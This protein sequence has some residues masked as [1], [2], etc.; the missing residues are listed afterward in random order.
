MTTKEKKEKK[1]KGQFCWLCGSEENLS[2]HHLNSEKVKPR[3]RREELGIFLLKG[4]CIPLCVTCHRELEL[5]QN[6]RKLLKKLV[7]V[8]KEAI[9]LI[10]MS[11]ILKKP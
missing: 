5:V 1:L 7:K 3:E 2:V 4:E 6:Q 9:N 8:F 11:R 10:G